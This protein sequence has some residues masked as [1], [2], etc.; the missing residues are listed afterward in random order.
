MSEPFVWIST[1]AIRPGKAEHYRE[2]C[3]QVTALVEAQEPEMLYF[4]NCI[5]EDGS[6]VSTVQ[7]HA[8]VSNLRHH[9]EVV[10]P[11]IGQAMPDLDLTQMTVDIYGHIP[12]PL[13]A[14]VRQTGGPD[15]AINVYEP[16]SRR[17]SR[18]S[19]R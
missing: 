16:P 13:L 3:D 17:L 5:S 9:I 18:L 15:V 12:E 14:Q 7:V 8:D 4:A 10:G 19:S 11:L 6:S 1:C 2:V